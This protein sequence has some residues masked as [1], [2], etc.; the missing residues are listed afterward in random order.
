MVGVLLV[1]FHADV[2]YSTPAECEG[3]T[4]KPRMRVD[5]LS[6]TLYVVREDRLCA[7]RGCEDTSA[8]YYST[9]PSRARSQ[10]FKD[11]IPIC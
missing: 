7:S 1:S 8:E 6:K 9:Y 3:V 4:F 2:P 11:C 5:K 10:A